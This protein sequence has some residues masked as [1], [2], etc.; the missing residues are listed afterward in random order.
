MKT[1]TLGTT[2]VSV[3]EIC[4]GAMHIGSNTPTD[5]STNIL[6]AYVDAG[7]AFIDTA[8]I[9]NRDAPGCSGGDSERFIGSWLKMRGNRSDLF[10]ATKVGMHYPDQ[11]EGLR[12][13]QIAEECEKS[14][15]RLGIDTI[16]LYYAHADDRNTPLEESLRAFDKLVKDGKVRFIAASN[17]YPTRL[18]QAISTSHQLGLEAYCCIQQRYAYLRPRPGAS[19][20]IQ[21]AANDDLIDYC[22]SN[23]F[24]LIAYA[25][26]LKGAVAGRADIPI[27][28]RYAS[29]DSLERLERL[30]LV[31]QDLGASPAQVALA[32]MRR[33]QATVI[34]LIGV[35][36]TNQL[37][38]CLGMLDLT[39]DDKVMERLN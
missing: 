38:D 19:F 12:A 8:N 4:L 14:L 17:Y 32:W 18:V 11:P 28:D 24:P 16:D 35:S 37:N 23:D 27:R 29:E 2:G 10:I 22:Q 36:S 6:D 7:G 1:V 13:S 33:H 31:A 9:Y 34:P 30:K 20:G 25:P 15:Q 3:S 5:I 21:K 39:L 26:L